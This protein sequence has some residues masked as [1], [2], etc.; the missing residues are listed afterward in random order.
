MTRSISVRHLALAKGIAK[1]SLTASFRA[2]MAAGVGICAAAAFGLSRADH[3]ELNLYEDWIRRPCFSALRL[4]NETTGS[5]L[6]EAT[7]EARTAF[8]GAH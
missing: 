4:V 2:A 7:A 5:L 3:R 8:A 6:T 1:S